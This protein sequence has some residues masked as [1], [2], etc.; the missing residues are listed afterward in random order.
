MAIMDVTVTFKPCALHRVT[1]PL[2]QPHGSWFMKVLIMFV[3]YV[4]NFVYLNSSTRELILTDD[5]DPIIFRG[6]WF[7]K[8]LVMFVYYVFNF[9]YLNS[10]RWTNIG[11][12]LVDLKLLF[13]EEVATNDERWLSG[14]KLLFQSVKKS[15]L[16]EK[17]LSDI[18]MLFHNTTR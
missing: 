16:D 12:T 6:S 11:R 18:K 15:A 2:P 10:S 9:V 17:S 14:M 4:F 5:R 1:D 13:V 8:V 7:M 3:Y